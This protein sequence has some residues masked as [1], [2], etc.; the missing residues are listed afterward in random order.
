LICPETGNRERRFV[1]A[2]QS[3]LSR[4]DKDR[5]KKHTRKATGMTTSDCKVLIRSKRLPATSGTPARWRVALSGG[6]AQ[7]R[8]A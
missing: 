5:E 2:G 4:F 7:Q 3:A 1:V 6:L 8:V